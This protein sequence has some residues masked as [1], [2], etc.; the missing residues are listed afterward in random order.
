MTWSE[1]HCPK[2]SRL[3][4]KT[5]NTRCLTPFN[6]VYCG[7]LIDEHLEEFSL[8]SKKQTSKERIIAYIESIFDHPEDREGFTSEDIDLMSSFLDQLVKHSNN[9]FFLESV[10]LLFSDYS[11][12]LEHVKSF[13]EDD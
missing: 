8:P 2:C 5:K 9:T 7:Y 4:L 1:F 3:V 6:C 11:M 12:T 13:L 10:C